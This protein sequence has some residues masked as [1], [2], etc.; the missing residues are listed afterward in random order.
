MKTTLF[1]CTIFLLG[2]I[3]SGAH[4]QSLSGIRI[5]EDISATSRLG[6][7]PSARKQIGPFTL[8][9]WILED[10]NELS[11]TSSTASGKIVYI[12]TDWGG[13][14]TGTTSDFSLFSY[15]RTTL[16]EIRSQFGNN[17]FS[18]NG[19]APRG[20][21]NNSIINMNSYEIANNDGV[22]V[23][24]VTKIDG[25]D[26]KEMVKRGPEFSSHLSKLVTII[27]GDAKYLRS[28]WGPNLVFDPDYE[29]IVWK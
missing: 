28:I 5:G 24:F 21:P 14:Q 7:P 25:K 9:K 17:G 19:G 29:R 23:T 22:I 20:G 26:V 27:L 12:E 15:G 11:V 3:G 4:S 1:L 10:G 13:T 16:A 8:S 6:A 2:A 18:F